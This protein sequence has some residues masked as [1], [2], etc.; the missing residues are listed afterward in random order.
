MPALDFVFQH[1]IDHLV[2]L[3]DRQAF[4]LGGL[5]LDGIHGPAAAAD[6]LYLCPTCQQ[7]FK[8]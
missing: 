4:E 6:I 2:L 3:D 1:F 5:D 7:S 8:H